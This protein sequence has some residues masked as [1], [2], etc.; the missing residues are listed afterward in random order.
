MF[1]TTPTASVFSSQAKGKEWFNNKKRVVKELLG[2]AYN[3]VFQSDAFT[4]EYDVAGGG[5]TLLQCVNRGRV[6]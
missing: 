3:S 4:E 6:F 2:G 5:G 1:T